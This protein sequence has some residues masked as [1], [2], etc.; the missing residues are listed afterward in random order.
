MAG[1]VRFSIMTIPAECE[2]CGHRYRIQ[3]RFAG[4]QLPCKHCGEYFV[5][6]TSSRGPGSRTNRRSARGSAS[7]GNPPWVTVA[8]IAGVVIGCG[9]LLWS[10]ASKSSDAKNDPKQNPNNPQAEVA[11]DGSELFPVASVPLPNFPQQL[12]PPVQ[13]VS[14]ASV[15]FVDLKRTPGNGSAPGSQ[16]AMRI[17]LPAGEHAAR[18]L[19]CVLVA[20]AGSNLLRGNPMDADDYHKETLP[21]VNAGYAVVFYSID[22]ILDDPDNAT[23]FAMSHAY[24]EFKA[25]QAGVVNGRNALEFVLAKLPAVDPARIYSAGHSSAGVLSLLLAE[26]EPRIAG[27]IAYAPASDVELRLRE[28]AENREIQILM[29]GIKPFLKQSSPKTHAQDLKCP[30]FL[31][32]ALDD[33]NE[34]IATTKAFA[35]QLQSQGK[36]PTFKTSRTG[37]HYN[38]M[39]QTGIPLAITWLKQLPT[40]QGKTYPAPP[41]E[42]TA[43]NPPPKTNPVPRFQP[44]PFRP[45]SFP[46]RM[47]R[48][49]S[50]QRIMV[51]KL[52]S[53]MGTGDAVQTAQQ[54]LRRYPFCDANSVQVDFAA[55]E[56][57]INVR[58]VSINSG[59]VKSALQQAGFQLGG[60]SIKF[61]SP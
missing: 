5:V 59:P 51:F 4:E 35:A 25:A 30:V 50:G 57:I 8:L 7:S 9:L 52:Q 10:L 3:D 29:P 49:S 61:Q 43:K 32:H 14:G 54:V 56:V 12:P 45:P 24:T 1:V 26:H 41:S 13:K 21:Y 17:Y 47:P 2:Y 33:S 16:M 22:G 44:P 42:A 38:S 36:T 40:E 18:S 28:A 20:P 34:P 60:V 58:G 6:P 31:F 15:Y 39:I 48:P 19:G 37:N 53:Y 27:A 11:G 46:P 55:K 23:G